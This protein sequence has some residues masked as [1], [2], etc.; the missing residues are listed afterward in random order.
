M[1]TQTAESTSVTLPLPSSGEIVPIYVYISNAYN[2]TAQVNL[3][4]TVTMSS[5]NTNEFVADAFAEVTANFAQYPNLFYSVIY[6]AKEVLI[7]LQIW[8]Q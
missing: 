5:N 2:A 4:A 8:R 6:K 7:K 3:T 1:K